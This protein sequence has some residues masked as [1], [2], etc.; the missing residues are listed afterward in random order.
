[1]GW[2][3]WAQR[4][5][6]L[7]RGQPILQV[8]TWQA[9]WFGLLGSPKSIESSNVSSPA[10]WKQPASCYTP[11]KVPLRTISIVLVWPHWEHLGAPPWG[12]GS[13]ACPHCGAMAQL[14]L[15]AP[16]W[17][18]HPDG[19]LCLIPHPCC[20]PSSCNCGPGCTYSLQPPWAGSNRGV[21]GHWVKENISPPVR[22]EREDGTC[23]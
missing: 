16:M 12:G 10:A 8:W 21:R 9:R 22:R 6:S 17:P 13:R 15:V 7:P 3:L 20:H 1:M 14:G 18:L 2:W 23:D 5:R 19:L 4:L 11:G